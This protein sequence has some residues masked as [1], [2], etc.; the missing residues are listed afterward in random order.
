M[1]E[2]C[3]MLEHSKSRQEGFGCN[4]EFK[5]DF[6]LRLLW[7]TTSNRGIVNKWHFRSV[8]CWFPSEEWSYYS[9]WVIPACPNLFFLLNSLGLLLQAGQD[10]PE[11]GLLL[12]LGLCQQ[13]PLGRGVLDGFGTR[14]GDVLQLLHLHQERTLNLLSHWDNGIPES[15]NPPL[16][17]KTSQQLAMTEWMTPIH[18]LTPLME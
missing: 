17:P 5:I 15:L 11:L 4:Y 18:E 16:D 13:L 7:T 8:W 6:P 10:L 12:L 2:L 9:R 3:V 14:G 1:N